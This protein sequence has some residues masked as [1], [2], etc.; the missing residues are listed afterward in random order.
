M[1]WDNISQEEDLSEDFIREHAD[2][3]HWKKLSLHKTLS[4]EFIYEMEQYVDWRNVVMFHPAINE[5]LSDAIE[6]RKKEIVNTTSYSQH[7]LAFQ[8]LSFNPHLNKE[9]IFKYGCM[10][11]WNILLFENPYVKNEMEVEE[12]KNYIYWDSVHREAI[13]FQEIDMEFFK[14][15]KKY[16]HWDDVT[17]YLLKTKFDFPISFVE[18][19]KEYINWDVLLTEKNFSTD[20]LEQYQEYL[21]WDTV[22][23]EQT[24]SEDFIETFSDLV[25]WKHIATYQSLSL[26]FIKKHRHTINLDDISINF[27]KQNSIK[28][29]ES[30]RGMRKYRYVKKIWYSFLYRVKNIIK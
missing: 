23:K 10:L 27:Y 24:L 18:E 6:H 21:I 16:L 9:N 29:L 11:N 12:Y 7:V 26:P 25:N 13:H 4:K 19:Y 20:F 3:L 5:M 17:E 2:V 30:F 22:S 28:D 15:H 14:K 8:E 1:K